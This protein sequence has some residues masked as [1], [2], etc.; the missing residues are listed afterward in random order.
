MII[1]RYEEIELARTDLTE[2][3]LSH[4]W[5]VSL[6]QVGSEIGGDGNMDERGRRI[7][8]RREAW[9]DSFHGEAET[10]M[11]YQL[12]YCRPN[13]VPARILLF[14]QDSVDSDNAILALISHTLSGSNSPSN[15]FIKGHGK[16]VDIMALI[17]TLSRRGI[18]P[19]SLAR[20]YCIS[21]NDF[22]H[23][24]DVATVE[25]LVKTYLNWHQ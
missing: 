6:T 20:L 14:V 17:N 13:S 16:Y 7:Y 4:I 11:Q 1:E 15:T 12:Y 23:S 18:D 5:S 2:A 10:R 9:L 22:N 3:D 8:I 24:S 19:L 21:G 25:R